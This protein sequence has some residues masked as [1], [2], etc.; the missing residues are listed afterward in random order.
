MPKLIGVDYGTKRVGVAVSDDR[1]AVAFPK[2]IYPN[3][4][5][6]LPALVALIQKEGARTVV[7]GESKN[8]DGNDNP[9][10]RSARTF[11]AELERSV[12]VTVFFEPEF[13]TSVEARRVSLDAG[14]GAKKGVDAEAATIILNSYITRTTHS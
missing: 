4:R 14:G 2:A 10:M 13:Y 3:D 9:V 1:G 5:A 7:M 12:P 6:L 8:S 11:A